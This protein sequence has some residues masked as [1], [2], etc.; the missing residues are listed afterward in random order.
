MIA[1]ATVIFAFPL[2]F[3]L[4]NRLAACLAYVAIFACSG[5]GPAGGGVQ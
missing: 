4:R 3:L 2:G 5:L 1:I